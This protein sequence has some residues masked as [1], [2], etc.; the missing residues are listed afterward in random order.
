VTANFSPSNFDWRLSRL[1]TSPSRERVAI[2]YDPRA[3][4]FRHSVRRPSF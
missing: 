4:Q 3:Y 2:R 1:M